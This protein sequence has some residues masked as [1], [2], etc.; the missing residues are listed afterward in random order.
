MRGWHLTTEDLSEQDKEGE[1]GEMGNSDVG[2]ALN[3]SSSKGKLNVPLLS[4]Q[5][6][7]N[8]PTSKKMRQVLLY[9]L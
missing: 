2:E 9:G 7:D 3:S 8:T 4:H 6:S 5:M 1:E